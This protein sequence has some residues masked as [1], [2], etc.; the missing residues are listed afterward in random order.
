MAGCSLQAMPGQAQEAA[1]AQR[2]WGHQQSHRTARTKGPLEAPL[3]SFCLCC[4]RGAGAS[5]ILPVD[6]SQDIEHRGHVRVVV[7]RA[8]LQVLQGLFAKRHSHLVAPLRSILDHQ[9]VQ[10][11]QACWDLVPAL[12]SCQSGGTRTL[13]LC[14]TKPRLGGE[15]RAWVAR[16]GR[17]R[18]SS[19]SSPPLSQALPSAWPALG[20]VNVLLLET[21]AAL[22]NP[23]LG[24]SFSLTQAG[25]QQFLRLSSTWGLTEK[26]KDTEGN[27]PG[28]WSSSVLRK[29][30][31]VSTCKKSL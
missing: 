27:A 16:L 21:A 8:L 11:P 31:S 4:W 17:S 9:V 7:P 28:L 24:L 12:L 6:Q 13:P 29:P 3:R 5:A 26:A 10:R 15:H 25:R 14:R 30:S 22:C 1:A 20:Q 2:T 19:W 18:A 23:V